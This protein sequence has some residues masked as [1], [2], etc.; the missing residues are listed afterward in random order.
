MLN[1]NINF[2]SDEI[3][4]AST[5]FT[6]SLTNSLNRRT[7]NKFL[8]T[9]NLNTSFLIRISQTCSTVDWFTFHIIVPTV[10]I[11]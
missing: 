11:L 5:L 2:L 9:L 7:V 8:I 10:V 1:G 3:K 4:Q 6:F